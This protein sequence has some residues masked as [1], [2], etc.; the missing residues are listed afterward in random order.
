MIPAPDLTPARGDALDPASRVTPHSPPDR[1][2]ARSTA[3]S[4]TGAGAPVV[5]RAPGRRVGGRVDPSI[6]GA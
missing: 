3:R 5:R 4:T 2:P 6:V 1:L